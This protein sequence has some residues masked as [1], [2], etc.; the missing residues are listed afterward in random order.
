M[1]LSKYMTSQSVELKRSALHLAEYNPRTITDEE[2]K[3]LKRGIKKFGLVGGIV[4][5]KQTGLTIVSGHQRISVMDELQK[6]NPD[7]NENDYKLY[8][9]RIRQ[10]IPENNW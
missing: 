6:Y 5:N 4:V 3:T 2:K 9:C 8:L 1:E 10:N 7:T